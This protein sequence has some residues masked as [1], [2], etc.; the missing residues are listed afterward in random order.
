M[1]R[2][3]QVHEGIRGYLA[4]SVGGAFDAPERLAAGCR[5]WPSGGIRMCIGRVSL[6]AARR[7]TVRRM[8]APRIGSLPALALD[9]RSM[10][11]RVVGRKA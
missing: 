3:A 9:V 4:H 7:A 2:G 10:D 6:N 11:C 1:G 8:R 5:K